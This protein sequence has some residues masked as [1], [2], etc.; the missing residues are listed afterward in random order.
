MNTKGMMDISPLK[1]PSNVHAQLTPRVEYI[2]FAANGKTTPK[3]L[4][5]ADVAPIALAANTS[6]ASTT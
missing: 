2:G 1:I 5:E 6:Y 3:M 4:R